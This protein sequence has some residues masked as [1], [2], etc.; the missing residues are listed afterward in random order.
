MIRSII[1]DLGRVLIP[2]DFQLGYSRMAQRCGLSA[3]EVRN[4][5]A[6]TGIV[7]EF[8]HGRVE[9]HDFVRQ[10]GDC[11]GITIGYDEFSEIWGAIFLPQTLVP[12]EFVVALRSK[13]RMVLL[14]NTNALH[15]SMLER[16]YSILKHFDAYV[17][18]YAVNSMKPEPAIYRAAI[19]AAQCEPAECFFTDDMGPFV[20]AALSHGIDAV[21][22]KDFDQLRAELSGRGVVWD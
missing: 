22:F 19:A 21:Q 2:F 16:R 17:L 11:L 14:S 1:F 20:E 5:L 3:E 9:S 4:R 10:V 12:E 7:P 18:S 6:H 8:E 15:Y 13:Y